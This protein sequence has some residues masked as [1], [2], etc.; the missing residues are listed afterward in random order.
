MKN[1]LMGI[2]TLVLYALIF[3]LVIYLVEAS[4]T[5]VSL[6]IFKLGF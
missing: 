4:T 1:F 5:V 6:L 2:S 3:L